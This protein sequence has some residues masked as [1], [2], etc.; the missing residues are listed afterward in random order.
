MSQTRHPAQTV[1]H[2]PGNENFDALTTSNIAP[3]TPKTEYQRFLK[4]REA[5]M[6][7]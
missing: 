3:Y 4:D 6:M 5:T 1:T 2:I 7:N